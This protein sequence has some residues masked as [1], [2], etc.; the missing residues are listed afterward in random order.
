MATCEHCGTGLDDGW[1]PG[2]DIATDEDDVRACRDLLSGM[3]EATREALNR[4]LETFLDLEDDGASGHS[5]GGCVAC[6]G[7]G[8][9]NPQSLYPIEHMP[10]CRIDAAIKRLRAMGCVDSIGVVQRRQVSG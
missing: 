2:D 4:D 10:G 7:S 9:H 1:H 8:E 3:L 5:E 6:W